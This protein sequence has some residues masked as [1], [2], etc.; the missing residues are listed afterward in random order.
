MKKLAVN[1]VGFSFA[2]ALLSPAPVFAGS[3]PSGSATGADADKVV[4]KRTVDTGSLVKGRRICKTKAEWRSEQDAARQEAQ[5]MQ[6]RGMV[7]SE[8]P[9]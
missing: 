1:S 6:E 4:C 9:R 5:T 7:N 3:T 2:I 8:A